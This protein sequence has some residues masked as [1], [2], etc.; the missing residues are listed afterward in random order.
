MRSTSF[1]VAAI[2]ILLCTQSC[3]TRSKADQIVDDAIAAHGGEDYKHAAISFDFRER[4]YTYKRNG[5]TFAYTREFSDSTGK[6]KDVLNNEGFSRTVNGANTNM[7]E[8][9]KAAFSNSVNSVIYFALLPYGLNDAAVQKEYL[10]EA[11]IAGSSYHLIKVT[12]SEEG[13]GQDFEDE[14]LY[15]FNTETNTMDYLAYS[16]HTEGGGLRFRKAVNPRRV[17]GIL[18]QDYI[19]YKPKNGEVALEALGELYRQDSLEVL[20]VIE[21]ENIQAR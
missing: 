18:F 1:I 6:V 21:L 9:R 7:T 8:E 10:G 15:W 4:H 11:N 13:G 2:L 12:F 19:N 14:F 3:K 17:G 5:G 20:S 16:Y